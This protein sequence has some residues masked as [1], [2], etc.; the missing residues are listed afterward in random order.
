VPESFLSRVLMKTCLTLSLAAFA[1]IVTL[2]Q[3]FGGGVRST[4]F[5]ETTDRTDHFP[6]QVYDVALGGMPRAD[7]AEGA[8]VTLD[9][10]GFPTRIRQLLVSR[11]GSAQDE[12]SLIMLFREWSNLDPVSMTGWVAEHL[13]GEDR[14]QAFKQAAVI[15]AGNDLEAAIR[16][17]EAL[18]DGGER[19]AILLEVGFEAARIDPR[20]AVV[21]AAQMPPSK[22]RD[23]LIVQA[24][25][26]WTS[27]D[28]VSVLD[29]VSELPESRSRQ[30]ILSA[31]AVSFSSEDGR[32]A[33]GWVA[34]AM[35][36]GTEQVEASIL[37]ARNWGAQQP[38]EAAEW[39]ARFPDTSIRRQ[40]LQ[41]LVAGWSIRSSKAMAA[42]V[43]SLSDSALREEALAAVDSLPQQSLE[44]AEVVQEQ[45]SGP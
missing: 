45:T 36:G 44:S 3:K 21:L 1:V 40:A 27:L 4:G 11:L 32:N 7:V 23:E 5:L 8:Q 25:R 39:I 33:A 2:C 19:H 42:W 37:V 15:W 16:W 43:N 18:S 24:A 30:E 6:V 28:V 29:W 38:E 34:D 35:V 14:L 20:R 26:E 9:R 13:F 41:G 22:L 17:A 31:V 10:S 12:V